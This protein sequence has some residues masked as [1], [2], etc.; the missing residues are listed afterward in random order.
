MVVGLLFG[1]F[2]GEYNLSDGLEMRRRVNDERLAIEVLRI[3]TDSLARLVD[4]LEN[5]SSFQEREARERFGMIR[6]GETMFRI[7]PV[8]PDSGGDS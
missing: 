6:D 8:L 1:L 3:E 4:L 7:A 2:A 5:D